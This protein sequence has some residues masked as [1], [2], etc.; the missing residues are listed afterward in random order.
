VLDENLAGRSILDALGA[1][2]I[3]AIASTAL[4]P[5]GASDEDLLAA[6][7][8]T[9]HFLVSR[10]R[11]FRY[12]RATTDLAASRKMGRFI[13]TARKNMTGRDFAELL[14][15]AWPTIRKIIG[16]TKRPFIATIDR[17]G[18]IRLV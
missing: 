5:A 2:Q 8:P 16:R 17:A 10:D 1:H 13:I 14:I 9:K 3:P 4:V 18:K 15:R 11:D 12:H 6:M 7:E